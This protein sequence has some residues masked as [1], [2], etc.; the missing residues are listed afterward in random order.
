MIKLYEEWNIISTIKF[1]STFFIII[2]IIT[3]YVRFIYLALF[4]IIVSFIVYALPWIRK[5]L[6]EI[7]NIIR[8]NKRGH[9]KMSILTHIITF[10]AMFS[11]YYV[12][13]N[14]VIGMLFVTV[15]GIVFGDKSEL[16]FDWDTIANLPFKIFGIIF[17]VI[18]TL[19]V[20]YEI[21]TFML[22]KIK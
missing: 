9:K 2:G 21:M 6:I 22:S 7:G 17:V 8:K 5:D 12:I 10:V 15:S 19:W 1:L 16:Y 20:L 11:L 4:I 3:G 13:L 14:L 18:F